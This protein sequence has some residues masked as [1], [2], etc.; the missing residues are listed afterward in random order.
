MEN[1]DFEIENM[2]L[3]MNSMKN[4]EEIGSFEIPLKTAQ[5]YRGRVLCR[6][7]GVQTFKGNTVYE[8]NLQRKSTC[9]RSIY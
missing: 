3:F 8:G 1:S 7:I 4:F 2:N 5:N 6:I 9:E